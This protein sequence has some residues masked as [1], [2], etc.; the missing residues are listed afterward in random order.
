MY[1]PYHLTLQ[2][3]FFSAFE[4]VVSAAYKAY[5]KTTVSAISIFCV[6]TFLFFQH[7]CNEAEAN[8]WR[9]TWREETVPIF[10]IRTG[11]EVNGSFFLGIGSVGEESYYSF[12]EQ[13]KYGGLMRVHVPID[14]AV[15]YER[16]GNPTV[17]WKRKYY[18]F[19]LA[20]GGVL[21]TK[22]VNR[23]QSLI[24][25][26]KLKITTSATLLASKC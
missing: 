9:E 10:S 22:T 1:R 15:I 16:K 7:A 26:T 14:K 3:L 19:L 12:Y 2:F 11:S 5:P 4:A 17:L 25:I 21:E 13:K 6:A 23:A 20:E 18:G 8:R 24:R